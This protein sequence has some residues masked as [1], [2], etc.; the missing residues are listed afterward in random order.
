[1][2]QYKELLAVCV[3]A[4]HNFDVKSQ[5]VEEY[6]RCYLK[7]QKVSTLIVNI[8]RYVINPAIG[9]KNLIFYNRPVACR[10]LITM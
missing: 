3:D 9:F 10:Y 7:A 4:F 1:M 8:F 6:I 2:L 5:S